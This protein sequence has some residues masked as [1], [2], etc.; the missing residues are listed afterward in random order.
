MHKSEAKASESI[1]ARAIFSRGIFS[2]WGAVA[3]VLSFSNHAQAATFNSTSG[4][5]VKLF[6]PSKALN[7]Y[8]MYMDSTIRTGTTMKTA[9]RGLLG[10]G[11]TLTAEGGNSVFKIPSFI[12]SDLIGNAPIDF[13]TT[14]HVEGTANFGQQ[15]NLGK[16]GGLLQ[17]DKTLKFAGNGGTISASTWV[18][19]ALTPLQNAK[20][21]KDLYLNS[22]LGSTSPVTYSGEVYF[23]GASG[24]VGA[25]ETDV[26][27]ALR[28]FDVP[29]NPPMGAIERFTAPQLPGYNI[30]GLDD[31][32]VGGLGAL[33]SVTGLSYG[34][35]LCAPVGNVPCVDV[36]AHTINGVTLPA[37]KMLPAG[38]YGALT[39]ANE[40]VY[41]GEGVYYFD[42]V[43]LQNSGA[44]LIALQP[45][46]GRT[47][48]FARNGFSTSSGS[49]FVGP[50]SAVGATGYGSG[51][52]LFMGG[53]MMIVA[54]KTAG[55]NF[56][57]DAYIWATLSAP[58]GTITAN[59]QLHLY[60]QMFARH[61]RAVNNFDGG[62]GEFVPFDPE[63]PTINISISPSGT[64]VPEADQVYYATIKLST[65]NAYA[66]S[67]KYSTAVAPA[68]AP[69]GTAVAG[70]NFVARTDS[71]VIIK[72]G[73]TTATIPFTIKWDKVV[74]GD[75][76]FYLNFTEPAGGVFGVGTGAYGDTS[77]V[78][79]QITIVDKDKPPALR[80][81][82]L[83][84]KEGNSGITTFT[85]N[86]KFVD[87]AT[88]G[89]YVG[90]LGR[91]ITFKWS[92][93]DGFGTQP[94]ATSA[95]GDYTAV[96]GATGTILKGQNSTTITVSVNGDPR[97]ELDESFK[98]QLDSASLV[99]RIATSGYNRYAAQGTIQNDDMFPAIRMDSVGLVEGNSGRKTY[100]LVTYLVGPVSGTRITAGSVPEVPM[101]YSWS[102]SDVTAGS[103]LTGT[104]KDTDYVAVPS[105]IRTIPAGKWTDTI[106]VDVVGDQK[107]EAPETFRINLVPLDS[108]HKVSF[109]A[110]DTILN[111]DNQP[112]VELLGGSVQEGKSGDRNVASFKIQ[113][114]SQGTGDL[115]VAGNAPTTP[116]IFTWSTFDS[117]AVGKASGSSD[118]DYVPVV[119]RTDTIPA[120]AISK[121]LSVTIL[122]DNRLENN[123]AFSVRLSN[124]VNAA[125]ADKNTTYAAMTILNDD[126]LPKLK[127]VVDSSVHEGAS[128]ARRNATF[129][130]TL[131]DING[132]DL[133]AADAPELPI[134]F[135]W[136]TVNGTALSSGTGVADTDYVAVAAGS[137]TL[138][139]GT[140]KTSL[141]VQVKGDNIQE[142]TETFT[143]VLAPGS[144]AGSGGTLT[145]TGTILDDD[146]PPALFLTGVRTAEGNAGTNPSFNFGIK[147]STISALP[148]SFQWSTRDSTAKVSD[149][150]YQAVTTRTETVQPGRDS[151]T[152]PVVV[153]GDDKLENDEIFSIKV[154]GLTGGATFNAG[155]DTAVG[156]ILND[157]AK[158]YIQV[159]A[160][161]AISEKN[162]GTPDTL[163][164]PVRLV[165]SNGLPLT[166]PPA[167]D[168]TYSW[169]TVDSAGVY[170]ARATDNDFVAKVSVARTIKA[171]SLYD[172]LKVAVVPDTRYENH[173]SFRVALSSI[174]GADSTNKAV[175]T[176]V[177]TILNDD[178]KPQI[179]VANDSVKE[180]A[181]ATDADSTLLF[182]VKLDAVSGLP[183]TVNYQTEGL[184]A[185]PDATVNYDYQDVSGTLTFAPGETS[186][187]VSVK[188]HGDNVY[189]GSTPE[190]VRFK[191]LAPV[192]AT[193]SRDTAIGYIV[194][195][196]AAPIL[197]VDTVQV[198]EGG[199]AN[200]TISLID[201]A[202]KPIVSGLPVTASWQTA[203]GTAT[204]N[205]DY[206]AQGS[207]SF[208]IPALTNSVQVQVATL[209]DNIANEGVETFKVILT[210][211]TNAALGDT[212]LGRILDVTPKPQ[213]TINDTIV[214][215]AD[216]NA[217]FTIR[218]DRPSATALSLVW[219]TADNLDKVAKLRARYSGADS[220]YT[221]QS[222]TTLS[223][224]ANSQSVTVSVPVVNNNLDEPDTLFYWAVIR[225]LLAGDTAFT[226]KD[227]IGVGGI[228]D[229]DAPP[230][231][232]VNNVSIQEPK[233]ASST[234]VYA[235]FTITLSSKSAQDISV[236]WKTVDSTAK[237]DSDFVTKSGTAL[238]KAGSLSVVD[239]IQV[240][241]DTLWELAEYFKL[242]LFSPV[243]AKF[244]DSLGVITIRDN[245]SAPAVRIDNSVITEPNQPDSAQITFK[246]RLSHVSGRTVVFN[247]Q[248]ADNLDVPAIRQAIANVDYRAV[249]STTVTIL[250]GDSVASLN[251]WVL[252]DNMSEQEERF[253][254]L[255]SK[256]VVGDT[257]LTFADSVGVG[258][259]K[260]ANGRPFVSINDTSMV[261]ANAGMKFRLKLTN[262]SSTDVNVY[263]HSE[264]QT[265]TAN[266]DYKK[267]PTSGVDTVV[268]IKAGKD[269]ATFFVRI[270]DDLL[271]EN[272]ESFKLVLDSTDTLTDGSMLPTANIGGVGYG[273]G[274]IFDNDSAPK[275]SVI[276]TAQQEPAVAGAS[277]T[278]KF[279]IHLSAP[280]G[281]P[282]SVAW[283]TLDGTA[284]TKIAPYDFV[285][286]GSSV[287]IRAGLSDTTI[288][289]R[290]LGDSLY[291]G[292][293]A[294]KLNLST[295][296]DGYFVDSSAVGTISDNDSAPKV[297][298][299][300]QTVREGETA[301]F[302]L[303]LQRESGLPLTLDWNTLEGTAKKD[304]DFKD[305]LGTVTIPAG[306]LTS[307]VSVRALT[308]NVS[309][310]G[311]EN[312]KVVLK[313]L[314][315]GLVGNDTGL[316]TILD[317][318]SLPRLSIDSV[319]R[320]H[321][322]DSV[323]HF[324][325]KLTGAPSAVPIHVHFTTHEGTATP[326]LRYVDTAGVVTI[327]AGLD[328]VQIPIHILDDQIREQD[329][330]FFTVVLDTA[331]SA[332]IAQP[333]GLG[334][335]LDDGDFPTVKVG[336][337]DTVSEGGISTFP[338]QVV[339]ATKDTV[340]VWWHTVDGS[341]KAG[342]DYTA[343]TGVVTF[344]PG[345]I[346]SSVS[347]A[348]L[349]DNLWEPTEGF[350]LRI[351][352]IRGASA[353]TSPSDSLAKGWIL[354]A[355]SIPTVWFL[356][357]DTTVAE[358]AGDSV[359][360]RIGLSR[361][362]SVDI[363]VTVPRMAGTAKFGNDYTVGL[364]TDTVTIKAGDT[365]ASFKVHV[366]SD[367]IDEYDETAVWDLKPIAP[368]TLGGKYEY[369]LTIQDDDSAPTV[370]FVKTTSV[371][372]EGDSVLVTAVLSRHSDKPIEAWYRTSGTA[373]PVV[374]NDLRKD[375]H[376]VF[377]FK[378]GDTLQ[379]I[380]VHTV[381]D[382]IFEPV[383]TMIFTLDSTANASIDPL[384]A[385][386]TVS[387]LNNDSVPTVSFL[388][389]D[390]TVRENVG[391]VTF[392]LKLSNPA[393]FP[394]LLN[395]KA[396]AG[397]AWLDS[398][399]RG[400]DA[401]L[402]T[403]STYTITFAPGDTTAT[404]SVRILD[405]GLVE[406]TESFSLKL[407]S[408]DLKIGNGAAIHILDND[409]LPVVRITRPTDSLRTNTPKQTIE[410]TF[411]GVP[412]AP[413]DT[414]LVSGW[415]TIIRTATD[416]AGNV[417]ADTIHVWGDFTP[418][419]IQ[420][421]KIT[422][423]N[424]HNPAKDT[425]WWGD[426]ARTRFGKDTIWY[427]VRDSI[428]NADGKSWRVV[429][430]THSVVT[431]FKGDGLFP[432]QVKTCDSVGNCA[433]DTGWIDL[434]QSLP[435][436]S[437]LTP[438]DGSQAVAGTL[439]VIHQVTD[440]NKTWDVSSTK[441]ISTPGIDTI[442][443]CYED[444]VGN[445][446]CDVHKVV[447][448][449]IHVISA[450]Y[451]DTD[452]DGR[453]DAVVVNLDS[454]WTSD[455]LPSFD[456]TL[457][458]STRTGQKPNATAP[459]YAGPSR[460][461]PVVV[462]KD[463]LWVSAG[464]YLLDSAGHVLKGADG[465]PLTNV[466]GDS[467]FGSDGKVL[468]D[469]L[470]RV[471]YKVPGP[472][473]VDS[474]R[475]L[476]RIVPPFAF[477]MTGFD[478]LQ[479]ATMVSSWTTTDSAGKPVV[480]KYVD[481]FKVDEKVPPVIVK[482]E[483][484]RVENY[485][486]PDTLFVTASEY[487]KLGK[488][489]DLLQVGR[490]PTGMKTCEA[491][492]LIWTDVPDSMV[493][494]GPD[495]RYW[496]LVYPDD[497]GIKPDYRVRFRSDVSDLK[498][499][500]TD[501]TNLNWSTVVSGAPRPDLVIMDPPSRIPSIPGSERDRTAP[502]GI[503]IR[504]TK[505][506]R[507][508]S[509][510]NLQWWEPGR[511]YIDANDESV[512][513][514][515]P[516]EQYCNGPTVY[517]NRPA[518]MIM[519][520][521]DNS[522]A[523][524]TSRTINISKDDLAKMEP[525][526]LDRVSI[527]LDWNHRNS[528]GKL[529]A[530]GIYVWRIVS[531]LQID[532]RPLPA[533]TNQ[534]F[535]VGVKIQ[536][537]GG[538]FF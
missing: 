267:L 150:D 424:T 465:F 248:T 60:G 345:R 245:D 155:K 347:I 492:S 372:V 436:V 271:H 297:Y 106:T 444:D 105:T 301:V 396:I 2:F 219:K 112:I 223:I 216:G 527:E 260:D 451:L 197:H 353:L 400:S 18:K 23:A 488:G 172:T 310:E 42:Q 523:F 140:L 84:A 336:N 114:R 59:S 535:K 374:D 497:L 129:T 496:F 344:L 215:E 326:G 469:S 480:T 101:K 109:T 369:V 521:Y 9:D 56:D 371:I 339:G 335:V 163:R 498:G 154:S 262:P 455:S 15:A 375:A 119:S 491:S 233:D 382:N 296:T 261:E 293:E 43:N 83:S 1:T 515:C 334:S 292:T 218:L 243:N 184:T 20:F 443:R 470:G 186:K 199:S 427:W 87:S 321:E 50:D 435:V 280:S 13:D 258:Y 467:A 405:D 512:R 64:K 366:V 175:L 377:Y 85:F 341:A 538:I 12:G 63:K 360:V 286:T 362:A 41:I 429:V 132:Q 221:A 255:L 487:L 208:T 75:L 471:L 32:T 283:S 468:R 196:D 395:L 40:V 343:D 166:V 96:S 91:D 403:A 506:V 156:V 73:D 316:G 278:M 200:F 409:T 440:A 37:G 387:I 107:F 49:I 57:S 285:D 299:D 337:A 158:P 450:T 442:L 220:N 117:T 28:N 206:T 421:F 368:I 392:A 194:D 406:P 225:K 532:G 189:E 122:G 11:Y 90:T 315:N 499:N 203:N 522:G 204:A 65:K 173:E 238:I 529:V 174:A 147:F 198:T 120:G 268:T 453:V 437:I 367:N 445:R 419:A 418:P 379:Q 21:T 378:A 266:S 439:P 169:S 212:G 501:T 146:A 510:T 79:A 95:S 17:F 36:P 528:Q 247:W 171:G 179:S 311:A 485:T 354:D 108:L 330:E 416:T 397:T 136:K 66:V 288:S 39:S 276:D 513:S 298:I 477:G 222:T 124:L 27:A 177:G 151:I 269:T 530:S 116:L 493:T 152:L 399:R 314:V 514:I 170:G 250:P 263:V 249:A 270:L 464:T 423:P 213:V 525:D 126:S 402:D 291:E 22:T 505:G 157:D 489:G 72:A 349:S 207:T 389:P 333:I 287:T 141:A 149:N 430:D 490:C 89:T 257:N 74:T 412:Q 417:A 235:K 281:L 524:V 8:W 407:S 404:F 231:I 290:I 446:G 376:E 279:R 426:K 272:A 133:S 300:S 312:F 62:A 517:V 472:G 432:T 463:T 98:V 295:V 388:S 54:G 536:P 328:S 128:T 274:T 159:L 273:I 329:E 313:N 252:S 461:T 103:S 448:E 237:H 162:S 121:T 24:S 47:I 191:L 92:T 138:N 193:I 433:V 275:V 289:V 294:F 309:G 411:Q 317:T 256:A 394:L 58:T 385:H 304:V 167:L 70:T 168:V 386:D 518:R 3:M 127:I 35:S 145:A 363:K 320:I 183:V 401:V 113:L 502:G 282:V 76:T 165:D 358:D 176:A 481:A 14:L 86:V 118:T 242:S 449:P 46:G 537:P 202:G 228:I 456:L 508:G 307:S 180:P 425:T 246:V 264:D 205:Y 462:G 361:P 533:M 308:D 531:Y 410:W 458:D 346:N 352:S 7:R 29:Y 30:A 188:V 78:A 431:D 370:G 4:I 318:N 239:S 265:T 509:S 322:A 51:P 534:L 355:G 373:T 38:Y 460:G 104:V 253:K 338:V 507:T 142:N 476:V 217:I 226:V 125:P 25:G 359:P 61:F 393:S 178:N 390:T 303:R 364:S 227:S 420:V 232:S 115:L 33:P 251:V 277:A 516:I 130:V 319:L 350:F 381:D 6:S 454:K 413:S 486:D 459:Y 483:I 391:V 357:P 192:T 182:V 214:S 473:K 190:T 351:D 137:V 325:V 195:N 500:A 244:S 88:G 519:Y 102:T 230:T 16:R 415:N 331:D 323:V 19:G 408:R 447:V 479:G 482:A 511:G 302:K 305:T 240:L 383:E 348:T 229:N 201:N 414:V 48:V 284:Q 494:R 209:S 100:K 438:P 160:A 161:N 384:R 478:T 67:F 111:D 526:Q 94:S 187:T 148:I 380:L 210:A 10:A 110:L 81:D 134:S 234:K 474:T 236:S 99:G 97:Y 306:Q 428:Q 398:A 93:A 153:N 457:N 123:E 452:G 5:D 26:P 495:G 131:T 139:P 31:A 520:I 434:K 340:R 332:R 356:S 82:D 164:F 484:H 504:T 185:Q 327:P 241:P 475:L 422:G 69:A 254:V 80:I 181:N 441:T 224:P 44:K 52:K 71:V 45:T 259:I 144:N 77:H 211:P 365:V 55:I 143:V 68:G 503:L 34:T 135:S 466:L 324:T 342:L 53:T